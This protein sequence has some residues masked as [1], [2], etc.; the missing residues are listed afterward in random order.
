[1]NPPFLAPHG[2]WLACIHAEAIEY[3]IMLFVTELGV[4]KPICRKFLGAI[5]HIF[6]TEDTERKHLFW[7]KIRRKP[8]IEV[9]ARRF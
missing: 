4:S 3:C 1:M 7:A 8:R 9:F 6:A 2:K 5:R